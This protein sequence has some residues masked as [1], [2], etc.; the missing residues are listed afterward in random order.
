MHKAWPYLLVAFFVFCIL[1]LIKTVFGVGWIATFGIFGLCV[2]LFAYK[3]CEPPSLFRG[4]GRSG[5]RKRRP[6]GKTTI[7]ADAGR[8]VHSG[9]PTVHWKLE[10][11]CFCTERPRGRFLLV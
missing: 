10:H 9:S 5:Q 4:M 8:D 2:L 3:A 6:R 7:P 11:C 1:C